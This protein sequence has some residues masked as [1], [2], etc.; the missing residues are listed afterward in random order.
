VATA[1]GRRLRA[2]LLV[3]YTCARPIA[4][5]DSNIP[6]GFDTDA[7]YLSGARRWLANIVMVAP[8]ELGKIIDLEIFRY[9]TLLLLLREADLRI[10]SVWH[11]S[12]LTLLLDSL[13]GHFDDLRSD[14]RTGRCRYEGQL[15]RAVANALCLKPNSKREKQLHFADPKH[16]ETIWPDLQVISCWG[17]AAA[18]SSC[19]DLEETFPTVMVQRKGLLATEAFVTIPFTERKPV[20]ITSHFFEFIDNQGEIRR[21]HELG[22]GEIYEVVVTTAGGLWRYR[23]GDRVA[24]DGFVNE[25]PSLRFIGRTEDICDLCGEKLS[26]QF[27][28]L[29]IDE[30]LGLSRPRFVMLAP[31]TSESGW[32]YTLYI[33]GEVPTNLCDALESVLRRN[34]N[35]AYCRDIGQLRRVDLFRISRGGYARYAHHMAHQG[36]RVG[37]IKPVALSKNGGWRHVFG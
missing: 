26:E 7:S 28:K 35:Y 32:R 33:E 14:I 19:R 17:D 31:D 9:V 18:E 15:P 30:V 13:C 1:P 5:R 21:V 23:L 16:P 2:I 4:E 29:A 11:P 36:N 8:P 12:F 27:V 22:E 10:I 20:A 24:V 37:D 34:P 3:D 25:W 6:I